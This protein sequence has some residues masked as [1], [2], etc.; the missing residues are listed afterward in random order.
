MVG[1]S[2]K[3]NKI[4]GVELTSINDTPGLGMK[5]KGEDFLSQYIGRGGNI[6]V[7][8]N[9]NIK[10]SFFINSFSFIYNILL[11]NYHH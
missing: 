5:A 6:G 4:T 9:E 10:L 8:K 3:D 2:C 1:I 7:N 11:Y